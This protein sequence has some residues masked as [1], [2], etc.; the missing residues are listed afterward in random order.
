MT[1]EEVKADWEKEKIRLDHLFKEFKKEFPNLYDRIERINFD[2]PKGWVGLVRALSKILE[3]TGT[4][5]T[6]IKQKFASLRFYV[7][8]DPL[9]LIEYEEVSEVISRFEKES[10]N[11]CEN[12]GTA[13]TLNSDVGFIQTLC[14][15]CVIIRDNK[16]KT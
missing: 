6:Q 8:P 1:T 5:C 7:K 4:R 16:W 14:K 2:V 12:C 15:K 3:P 9:G 11:I 10:T 13:G